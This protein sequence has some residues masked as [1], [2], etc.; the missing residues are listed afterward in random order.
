VVANDQGLV[1]LA[2]VRI[3]I[4]KRVPRGALPEHPGM[5]RSLC[6]PV[7]LSRRTVRY[8]G[9][10]VKLKKEFHADLRNTNAARNGGYLQ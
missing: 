5:P 7:I 4:R 3:G 9:K 6:Q 10:S 1:F 8:T 2:A